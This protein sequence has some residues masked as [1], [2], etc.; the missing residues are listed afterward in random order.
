MTEH[1][2][3]VAAKGLLKQLD[4]W[5]VRVNHSSGPLEFGSL[6][7]DTDGNG[8]RHRVSVIEVVDS[9]LVQAVH[10]DRRAVVAMWIRRPGGGWRLDLAW[11]GRHA[12]ELAPKQIT[13]TGLKTYVAG[14][15][16]AMAKLAPK[17]KNESIKQEIAA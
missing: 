11:R 6:S 4:D 5:S 10:V 9:V 16:V 17:T 13:A 12:G 14:G 2:T 7:E 3:P 8:K 15:L 1:E